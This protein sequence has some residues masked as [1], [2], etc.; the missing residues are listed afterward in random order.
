M[1]TPS[2]CTGHN[3]LLELGIHPTDI[4]TVV[5]GYLAGR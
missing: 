4:D 5:P 3:G 1:Q 2:I